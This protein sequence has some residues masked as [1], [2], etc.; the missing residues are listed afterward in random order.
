VVKPIKSILVALLFVQ[1]AVWA[2]S[3]IAA[4]D[5]NNLMEQAPQ[6]QSASDKM[7]KRFAGREKELVAERE[8][9]RELEEQ[10]KRDKDV[11]S[12]S[13]REEL[14]QSIRERLRDYKRESDNFTE[15]FSMARN[16]AL[17]TLQ[18]GVYKAIV[19]V[20]EKEKYDL[21]VS[22]GV[23]Y[24]SDR[25]DITDKVLAELQALHQKKP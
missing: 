19:S 24:A 4:V 25:V 16:E 13:K 5:I 1:S 23:L 22:E 14:E 3:R 20:A 15:D 2:E 7:K 8:K 17:D 9:I 21:V 6:A 18:D 10:Y 11:I 12:G